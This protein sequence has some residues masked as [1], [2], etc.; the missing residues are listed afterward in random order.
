M[1]SKV[2]IG[3]GNE[4]HIPTSLFQ[5]SLRVFK[6]SGHGT[7]GNGTR[8]DKEVEKNTDIQAKRKP[9]TA[10]FARSQEFSFLKFQGWH[11]EF[12][13]SKSSEPMAST[14]PDGR[15]M[16]TGAKVIEFPSC[17]LLPIVIC[18]AFGSAPS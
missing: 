9:K 4:P 1:K 3:S 8:Q 6:S 18:I 16:L 10:V 11:Q 17:F 7:R 15:Y 13:S 14:C 2:L 12:S 5:C